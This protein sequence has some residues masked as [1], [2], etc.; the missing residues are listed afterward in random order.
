MKTKAK[1]HKL[2]AIAIGIAVLALILPTAYI[3]LVKMEG[4]K[5]SAKIVLS[6]PIL[7]KSGIF[8]ISAGDIKS[9]IKKISVVL[10]QEGGEISLIEKDFPPPGFL[11]GPTVQTVREEIAVD[12][13]KHR[14]KDGNAVLRV[15]IDDCSWRKWGAGNRTYIEKEIQIDTKPPE[16]SVLSRTQNIA[17]GGSGLVIYKISE[18]CERSGVRVGDHFFPGKAGLYKNGN[19]LAAFFALRYDQGEETSLFLE[20]EDRAGNISKAGFPHYIKRKQFKSDVINIPDSFLTRK[21]PE[22][23]NYLAGGS[24][25]RVEKFLTINRKMRAENMKRFAEIVRKSD[26]AIHW[27][28]AFERL[29]NS[30]RR[31]GFA[32]HREYKYKGERID[33]QHHMGIDLASTSNAPVPASNGG[34]I[35]FAGYIGIFGKTV[36]IDHGFGL[37]STYSH[38]SGYAVTEGQTVKKGYR[39]GN[40]GTTGLAGGDHLHFGMLIHDVFVNPVE[41]WDAAWIKNNIT[42]KIDALGQE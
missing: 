27:K 26:A 25:D 32:D 21:L 34:R 20:A 15:A 31:A 36:V 12:A 30:A 24:S 19:I 39:I 14:I 22:F 8:S 42:A 38:L 6:S 41:W 9:G 37:F 5:P 28:G 17:Q 35:A 40:T 33:E 7:G 29:P 23:D 11:G 1:T 18:P 13:E 4:E 2:K 16:I 3:L 10:A